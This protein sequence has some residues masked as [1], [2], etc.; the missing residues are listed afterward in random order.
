[1]TPMLPSLPKNYREALAKELGPSVSPQ[2]AKEAFE[3]LDGKPEGLLFQNL[4]KL[5]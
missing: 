3:V 1:M 2:S 5:G 4:L